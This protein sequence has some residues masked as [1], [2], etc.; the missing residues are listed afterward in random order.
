MPL[1]ALQ[2]GSLPV[3]AANRSEESY[4]AGGIVLNVSSD[5][6]RF[7]EDFDIFHELAE[8]ASRVWPQAPGAREVRFV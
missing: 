1:T 6:A 7:P 2:E 5:S 4:S 3:L 8:A